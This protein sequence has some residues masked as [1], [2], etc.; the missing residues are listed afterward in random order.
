M[1]R[2]IGLVEGRFPP[3]WD[4][5]LDRNRLD[6]LWKQLLGCDESELLAL[7]GLDPDRADLLLA[8]AFVFRVLSDELGVDHWSLTSGGLRWGL[9]DALLCD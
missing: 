6:R 7:P 5:S 8:G 4:A 1:K 3:P 2:L 9:M